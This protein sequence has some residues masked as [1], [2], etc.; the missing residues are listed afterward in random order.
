MLSPQRCITFLLLLCAFQCH[1][2]KKKLKRSNIWNRPS[3]IFS[4]TAT[5]K[6]GQD[7]NQYFPLLIP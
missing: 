1:I 2:P 4:V 6:L 5:S 3:Q 7:P